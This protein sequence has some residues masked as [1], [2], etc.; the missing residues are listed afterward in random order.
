M[1]EYPLG[2]EFTFKLETSTPGQFATVAN[3]RSHSLSINN[4]PIDVTDKD[5]MPWRK[6]IAGGV[7]SMDGSFSGIF[8]DAVTL[9]DM[10]ALVVSDTPIANFQLVDGL[11][12]MFQGSFHVS[13]LDRQGDHDKET[14]YSFKIA[15]ADIITFT[16]AT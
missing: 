14:T 9:E 11:G 7:K 13:G 15:S 1:T 16:P 8:T 4:A 3:A 2:K 12:N 10:L 5:G 6:L